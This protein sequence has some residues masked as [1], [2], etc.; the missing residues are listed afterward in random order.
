MPRKKKSE[1]D[2]DEEEGEKRGIEE[3]AEKEAESIAKVEE[4][5]KRV[6][7]VAG[8]V[9]KT[10]AG[11]MVMRGEII[12]I[13]QIYEKNLPLLESEIV[14]TLLPELT[15]EVLN[16]NMV[17]RTTDSG[18]KASFLVTAAVGNK[19]GYVGVGTGKANNVR[20]AIQRAIRQAK[21]RLIN[22]RRSCGSWECSCDEPHS[23]P[24]RV[25][26]TSGSVK[27]VLFP[28]P[29]GTGIVAG[30]KAKKVLEL[31]GIKDVWSRTYGDTRT[32]FNFAMATIDALRKTRSIK[33][34]ERKK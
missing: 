15:D 1:D 19:D 22:V 12:G 21:L 32:T 31:A 30:Q 5:E 27:I 8:W 14:D 9:P 11:K 24:F 13:E 16:V 2:V 34:V 3:E 17:Q 6:E 29:K 10:K 18:R 33:M 26:G 25:E 23:I 4:R 28:A 7:A 20:P